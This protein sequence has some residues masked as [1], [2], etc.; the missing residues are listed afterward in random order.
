[1]REST[2]ESRKAIRVKHTMYHAYRLNCS[3]PLLID[4]TW[5]VG[6]W[7]LT[8]MHVDDDDDDYTSTHLTLWSVQPLSS[9]TP[10]RVLARVSQSGT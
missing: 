1:M 6:P 8:G 10:E 4:Y 9:H 3:K 2:G 5:L 7:S